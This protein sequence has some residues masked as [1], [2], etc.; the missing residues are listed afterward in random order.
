MVTFVSLA[1]LLVVVVG[2]LILRPLLARS[3]GA[4]EAT[5]GGA[6]NLAIL[7]EEGAL[8]DGELRAGNLD[9]ESYRNAREE[10]ERRALEDVKPD[11]AQLAAAARR[12]R[13][14]VILGV[15]FPAAVLALY[16][17][18]GA[19]Q[20]FHGETGKAPGDGGHALGPEQIVA[21]V[22]RLSEK[23][24]TNPNDG[25]GWLMLARS[26]SVLGRYPESA[27]AYGRA[28]SLLPPN[29][30]TLADFA[31]TVAMA[32]GRRLQG[33]PE[34]IVRRA[35]E[36]DPRNIKG[37]A[38]LGTILFEQGNYRG[39]IGEWNKVLALV[40]PESNVARGMQGSIRDAENRLA[41]GAGQG[42]QVSAPTA[43][44]VRGRV[45]LD[46][47]LADRVSP[48]DTVFVYAR[49]AAGPKMPL[50][51][52]RR[53]VADLPFEFT[54]DDSQAM[55]PNL[56]LSQ[57][58]QVVVSA[59]ISRSGDAAPRP[60]DWQAGVAAAKPGEGDVKLVVDTPVE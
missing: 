19:P 11:A 10:L 21:M 59:R 12:P 52:L 26:Y 55:S 4:A 43:T 27:A 1:T 40:P 13:M 25:E 32:Q 28:V 56:R 42:A 44:A 37:L 5:S 57:F 35:L 46:P 48:G 60:G 15:G 31:D 16:V 45:S 2:L 58:P 3:S 33:E 6:L 54:L 18:L 17:L 8:L 23:L 24:Q 47:R 22:E 39:A 20:A 51:I 50:A 30:Q 7:R 14:A 9:D 41:A 36:V 38:L 53:T 29:A 49:A 34:K